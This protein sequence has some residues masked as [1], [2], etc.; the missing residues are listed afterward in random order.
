MGG[1][2]VA[3]YRGRLYRRRNID[4]WI[5]HDPSACVYLTVIQVDYHAVNPRPG[6]SGPARLLAWVRKASLGVALAAFGGWT[7]AHQIIQNLC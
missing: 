7:S 4:G 1:G 6:L 2:R 5:R 3:F